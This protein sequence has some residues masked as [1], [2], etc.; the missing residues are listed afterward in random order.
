MKG[1]T[2]RY[3]AAALAISGLYSAAVDAAPMSEFDFLTSGGFFIGDIGGMGAY[4]TGAFG[5]CGSLVSSAIVNG[6]AASNCNLTLT[7]ED[8]NAPGFA[9]KVSWG[10]PLNTGSA[11]SSLAITH[12]PVGNSIAT[13]GSWVTIDQ[14]THTNNVLNSTGG[15]MDS[16]GVFGSF[17]LL[18]AP[19]QSA[20]PYPLLFT[21][22]LNTTGDT[23]CDVL[24]VGSNI[25]TPNCPDFYQTLPLVG[26]DSFTVGNYLYNISFRFQAG[27][28]AFVDE[29]ELG[30]TTWQRIWTQENNPGTSTVFTQARITVEEIPTQVPA[31]ATLFLLASS[32]LAIRAFKAKKQA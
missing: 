27:E 19:F 13:D 3:L 12:N 31:P 32:L 20:F 2:Q 6:G 8:P 25:A 17:K 9:Q 26:S 24:P 4:G 30:G 11:Q 18:N 22:T 21:E 29:V 10:T 7:N 15:W 5:T 1:L 23:P 14:F 16:I 28:G